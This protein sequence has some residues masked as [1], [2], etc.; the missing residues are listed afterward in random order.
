MCKFGPFCG[1][2]I[3]DPANG[4]ECDQGRDNTALYGADGCAPG[5]RIPHRCG[6]GFIDAGYGEICDDGVNNG[7]S[8]CA[9]NCVPR[10]D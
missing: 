6:D 4:E 3:P 10:V 2:G 5:C 9:V 7:T 8:R 1:D